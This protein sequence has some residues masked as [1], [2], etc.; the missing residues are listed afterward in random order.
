MLVENI[1]NVAL[2]EAGLADHR[3]TDANDFVMLLFLG[4]ATA[5]T[6]RGVISFSIGEVGQR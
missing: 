1:A 6:L 3:L 2:N 4:S 5:T